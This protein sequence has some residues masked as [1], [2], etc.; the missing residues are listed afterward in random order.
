MA[1]SPQP[2]L[3]YRSLTAF[4]LILGTTN[5]PLLAHDDAAQSSEPTLLPNN[6][7]NAPV[8]R[9]V[10]RDS[11][12]PALH[13]VIAAKPLDFSLAGR[14]VDI[15]TFLG[16]RIRFSAYVKT[17][18]KITNYVGLHLHCSDRTGKILAIDDMLGRGITKPADWTRLEVV[19]DIAPAATGLN[20]G[21][22]FR[23]SG[24]LWMD[25]AKIEV[26]GK[27]IP[28]TDDSTP[29]LYT[30]LAS[31]YTATLDPTTPRNGHPTVLIASSTQPT[32]SWAFYGLNNR[33]PQ[34]FANH[35]IRITGWAK[36]ENI[37]KGGRIAFWSI[38]SRALLCLDNSAERVS[39]KGT[40]DWKKYQITATIPDDLDHFDPGFNLFG[41]GK[42]WV[43]DL[44]YELIP[45][46]DSGL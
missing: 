2:S 15:A 18:G 41:N 30:D 3:F 8:D 13:F 37:T 44:K 12:P 31:N 20:V 38:G 4:L 19:A 32:N 39:I 6:T 45:D 29:H 22:Q 43:D 1:L 11:G 14:D 26:V 25:G 34:S 36:C 40:T 9:A 24:E 10:T 42:L 21:V 35:R 7:F 17:A 27:D 46:D 16:K 23:G 5:S 28:T 33:F